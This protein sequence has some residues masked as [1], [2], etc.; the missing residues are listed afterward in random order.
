MTDV[1][2]YHLQRVRLEQALPKLLEKTLAAGKRA[3]VVTGSAERAEALSGVLWTYDQDAWL[4][5]GTQRDGS[6]EQQPVWLDVSDAAP[7]GATFLFLTDGAA[8]SRIGDFER[9][10]DLF[11]GN[12][13]AAVAAARR[14]WKACKEAGHALTYWQQTAEGRWERKA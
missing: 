7:N 2:F 6:P 8:S 11:D 14:R 10:F 3:V 9:C 12:D 4:P 13:E 1:A 5:H